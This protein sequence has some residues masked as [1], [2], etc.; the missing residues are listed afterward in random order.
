M[1]QIEELKRILVG[2]NTEQLSE[3]KERVENI[4][5]RTKDVA[6][7]LAPAIDI[8]I[9]Q[10]DELV[11]ALKQPVSVGLKKAIRAEPT[12]YA[13]ILYPAIAPSIRLAISQAISSLLATINQTVKSATSFS[14]IRTRVE[15]ARTGVPYA[16]LVLRKSLLYRVEHVYLIDRESGLMIAECAAENRQSL[17]SDAVS[18][19]FSAIQSFVQDSFSGSDQDRLTDIT[20]GAH[21]VWIAH[22]PRAMLACVIYGEA[23]ETLKTQLYDTLDHISTAYSNPLA[24]FAGDTSRFLGVEDYMR[25]LLRLRLKEDIKASTETSWATKLLFLLVLGVLGIL[26]AQWFDRDSKLATL[27][28]HF[29]ETPGL[30]LTSAYW[31]ENQIVVEGLQDPDAELPI[32]IL[33]A[34]EIDQSM[35]SIQ[36]TPFRSLEPALELQRFLRELRPPTGSKFNRVGDSVELTGEAPINWLLQ[37]NERLRQLAADQRLNINELF[38]SATSLDEFLRDNLGDVDHPLYEQISAEVLTRP[39]NQVDLNSISPAGLS[40]RLQ[41]ASAQE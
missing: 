39:W 15:S 38:V 26:F 27:E 8:G 20:V 41:A 5:T 28:H 25:P 24:D 16:E 31:H 3:L 18:A 2:D 4:E 40:L 37:N 6:E 1:S 36:T 34:H 21:N 17:D 33:A 30:V 19:M 12:E 9:N 11:N 23:P 7:V 13:Q 14:G 32:A 10:S 22:S 35:L 29:S